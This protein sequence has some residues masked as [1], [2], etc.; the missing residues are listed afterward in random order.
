MSPTCPVIT[1]LVMVGT[2]NHYWMDAAVAGGLILLSEWT[3]RA[4][5]TA[6]RR[7]QPIGI[8]V[9]GSREATGGW[10][11]RS[12]YLHVGGTHDPGGCAT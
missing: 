2:G 5:W 12:K 3:A 11:Q 7:V 1:L 9:T 6:A 10:R 8:Q 4:W